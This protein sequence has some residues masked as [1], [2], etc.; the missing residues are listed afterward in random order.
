MKKLVLILSF[1]IVLQINSEGQ[2]LFTGKII[3]SGTGKPVG[4]VEAKLQGKELTT[5]SNALGF[6][7]LEVDSLDYIELNKPF[8]ETGLVKVSNYRSMKILF[9]KRTE[10]EYKEGMD[11]LLKYLCNNIAYPFKAVDH[12]TQGMVIVSF[13]VD[14]LGQLRNIQKITDL[15]DGCGNQ[16]V[17]ALKGLPNNWLP[18]ETV[19]TFILPVTF[20]SRSSN[21][22]EVNIQ[23]PNGKVIEEIVITSL[24]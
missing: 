15:G 16:V 9:Q 5:T 19:T 18:A 10:A 24:N 1:L 13:E 11:G 20:K 2:R 4:E 12:K 21:P 7:Q 23:L 17:E 6:F 8:Y 3:D 22:I 14:S